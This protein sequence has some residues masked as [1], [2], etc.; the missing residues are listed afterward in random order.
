MP[1]PGSTEIAA[2]RS[3]SEGFAGAELGE[4]LHFAMRDW[5]VVG[6][7][8]AGR[9][10]FNSEIWGDADQL[11]QAFRRKAREL[12]AQY[13]ADEVVKLAPNAITLRSGTMIEARTIVLAAGPS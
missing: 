9:T 4:T 6:I 12:G 10:G 3:I 1:R 11:M 8:D 13:V 7:F 5:K 2:G